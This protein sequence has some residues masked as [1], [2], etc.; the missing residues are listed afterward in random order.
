M[1]LGRLIKCLPREH[2]DQPQQRGEKESRPPASE[3][4][5]DPNTR[6]GAMAP[7]TAEPLSNNATAQ[8]RSD[9]GNHSETVLV[10]PGQLAA[11]PVPNRKRKH[12]KL[13]I[14]TAVEVMAAASE[15]Q[16][17]ASRRPRRL[18]N[19]SS[20]RPATVCINA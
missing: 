6:N 11:S 12:M 20:M 14:P 5:V 3:G 13:L 17:T 19:Q 8:P 2:P 18:P 15:Y 1:G 7:P 9:L 4:F 10:A 16:L